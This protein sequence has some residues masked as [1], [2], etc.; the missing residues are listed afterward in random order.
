MS[1]IHEALEKARLRQLGQAPGLPSVEEIIT[2]GVTTTE[3]AA[4]GGT[5]PGALPPEMLESIADNGSILSH[6]HQ[7]DWP[8]SGKNVVFLAADTPSAGQEQLRTLRSRLYQLRGKGT[9]K[10]IVVSSAMPGEGKSFLS[11]NLAH[12]FAL[13]NDQR[14]LVI[15]ADLRRA[16]GLTSLLE[17]PSAPGLSDYLLGEQSADRVIHTGSL[18]N[19]YLIP[20]GKRLDKPGEL[21]GEAKFRTL[22][23]QLRPA[24]DWII[25]DTPPILPVADARMIADLS[26]GVI[27]V[28]NANSTPAHL[29]K[30]GTQEFLRNK[31]LGVVLNRSAA[32]S[33]TYY[34]S[35]GYGNS[36]DDHAKQSK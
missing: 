17:A 7:G 5:A 36:S 14:A 4:S 10:V 26:D 29:A 33:A 20:C 25:I 18:K 30:R 2:A 32:P 6:C 16:G 35:Y 11:A 34:A 24:L 12:S 28:V 3:R 31:L 15:D 9:L 23:E 13:Q 8:V 1:R 19:L 22:I 27:F 21:V